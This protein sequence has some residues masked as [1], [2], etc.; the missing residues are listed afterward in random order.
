MMKQSPFFFIQQQSW[1]A[2]AAV[3]PRKQSRKEESFCLGRFLGQ[4]SSKV[5][6]KDLGFYVKDGAGNKRWTLGWIHGEWMKIQSTN[7]NFKFEFDELVLNAKVLFLSARAML[8][9]NS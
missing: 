9:L 7:N 2:R 6:I 4:I 8:K 5:K 3:G 1:V